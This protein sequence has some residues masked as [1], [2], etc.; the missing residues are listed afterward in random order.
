[1]VWNIS[2]LNW[3]HLPGCVTSQPLVHHPFY[4]LGGGVQVRSR[5]GLCV[6][7]TVS[8]AITLVCYQHH[9]SHK[10]KTQNNT[11]CYEANE[12]HPS[13]SQYN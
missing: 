11:S 3:G 4:S 5:N 7:S 8:I 9:F 2:L 6:V 1:M 10:P 12:L 13:Q